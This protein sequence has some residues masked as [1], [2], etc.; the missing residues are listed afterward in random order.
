M[1]REPHACCSECSTD[2]I[3]FS[4]TTL[5]TIQRKK[6]ACKSEGRKTKVRGKEGRQEERKLHGV[7][8]KNW[9]ESERKEGKKEEKKT[10]ERQCC[11]AEGRKR[12]EGKGRKEGRADKVVWRKKRQQKD[13]K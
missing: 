7:R 1:S 10:A 3:S 4:G 8:Q 5:S 13:G 2:L 6:G 11:M 12:Q 9:K